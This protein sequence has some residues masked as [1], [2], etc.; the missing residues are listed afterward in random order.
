[1]GFRKTKFQA[2]I[3]M[4]N[5]IG[6]GKSWKVMEKPSFQDG[7]KASGWEIDKLLSSAYW[8]FKDTPAR[9]EDFTTVTKASDFPMKF[10]KHR[11]LENVPVCERFIK[12]LPDLRQYVK[13]VKEGT[14]PDPKTKSYETIKQCCANH[15]VPVRLAFFL[16]VSEKITRF[17]TQYQTDK[18]MLPFMCSDLFK[19]VKD[20]MGRFM[21]SDKMAG[22]T[23]VYQLLKIDVQA[24]EDHNVYSK[25][26]IGFRAEK[27]LK[28]VVDPKTKKKVTDK[29]I[30]QFKLECRDFLVAIVKKIMDKSP[31]K[32]ALARNLSFMDPREMGSTAK[33]KNL[34]KCK[35]VLRQLNEANRV[36]DKDV[37]EILQQYGHYIDETVVPRCS[38]YTNFCVSTSRLDELLFDTMANNSSMH[39]LWSCVKMLLLLSHGQASVE[40]GFSVNKQVELDNL[41]EDT[42]VAKRIICDHVASV[43]GLQNIDAS[44]KQMLLAASSAR[45]KYLAYLEDEKKKK[46]SSGR[47]QKRK[48][49]NDEI[50]ELQNKKRCLQT[51]ID[52]LTTSAD[53]YAEKAEQ[54]HQVSWITKSNSFRRS[55]KEKR[56]EVTVVEEQLKQKL[57]ELKNSE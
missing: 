31:L 35:A 20:L 21:K 55:A 8:L 41:D 28:S 45:Q 14:V 46:E 13:A 40:R 50:D 29:E 26:D 19:V 30:M 25:I 33:E 57:Q 7:A 4:E 11:W 49:L 6:H 37:D 22:V 53:E 24:K 3:V 17:L 42:F 52:S 10:C 1:M 12:M 32:F 9:R 47:G 48:L 18:P 56:A 51:D 15:L 44:D 5:N 34:E 23:S 38:E 43:G 39:K 54:T 27:E 36:S 2:W 16:S